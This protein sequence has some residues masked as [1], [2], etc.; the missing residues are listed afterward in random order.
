M[1]KQILSANEL[2]VL[3]ALWSADRPL[4]R[5]EIL[6]RITKTDW[7]PNSINMIL[8]NLIKKGYVDVGMSVRCGQNYGRTYYPLKTREECIACLAA[9]MLPDISEDERVLNVMAAMTKSRGISESTI[10]K[11]EQMLE[12]RRKEIEQEKAD[13]TTKE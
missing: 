2:A 10:Q 5:P 7:N 4:A 8:N 3:T 12:Q 6:Q 9:N 1:K 11:L 13:P